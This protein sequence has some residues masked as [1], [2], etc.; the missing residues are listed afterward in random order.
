MR[1][2]LWRE[3]F[4]PEPDSQPQKQRQRKCHQKQDDRKIGFTSGVI[5]PNVLDLGYVPTFDSELNR[6][7]W[8]IDLENGTATPLGLERLKHLKLPLSP[9]IGCFGVAPPGGQAVSTATSSTHGRNMDYRGFVQGVKVYFPVFT[10]GALFYIGD[11]HAV[12]GDGEIVGPGIE[13]SF[14]VTFTV[15]LIKGKTIGCF[16]HSLMVPQR[17]RSVHSGWSN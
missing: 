11:G 14:D 3:Q 4:L 17:L 16:S 5:A 8:E 6:L 12:Q 15:D 7:N 13:I 1:G 10:A 9:M 2:L